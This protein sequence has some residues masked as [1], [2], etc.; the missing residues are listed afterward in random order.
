MNPKLS[1]GYAVQTWD[2]T[3]SFK[4]N[5]VGDDL[6]WFWAAI[7][8]VKNRLSPPPKKTVV[9][10]ISFTVKT[11]EFFG[12]LGANGAG[13][14]TLLKLLSGILY[15]D[16]GSGTVNSHDL[17]RDRMAVRKSVA[18]SKAQGWLGLLWQLSGRENLLFRAR[19]AGVPGREANKR[20]DEIL[21]R[22]DLARKAR[23]YSWELSAGET[24]KFNLATTF[25]S[26][27][28][29]VMLDE[30]TSH[31]DPQVAREV[32]AFIKQDLNKANGQTVIMSTHYLEEAD[33][34]CD[35]VAMIHEG[36]LVAFDS[37]AALRRTYVPDPILELRAENYASEIGEA[38]KAKCG[39]TEMIER[40]EDLATGRVRLRPKWPGR[41]GDLDALCG[42]LKAQ[43]V[44]ITSVR[45]VEPTLDDVYF[46]VTQGRI[47]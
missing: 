14:T 35:R 17:L 22:L 41:S 16:S 11:G 15:P 33:L 9:D 37:P 20:V 32:R 36:K 8:G 24:Q 7:V 40:F 13:K 3:K 10:H 4:A 26:R 30:P 29:L 31:L 12:I 2:L 23:S 25:I 1:S 18:T 39:L 28:P 45:S 42:E 43:G 38:A 19:M 34:L 47:K 46:Q 27:A 21:E 6:P 44:V 5:A